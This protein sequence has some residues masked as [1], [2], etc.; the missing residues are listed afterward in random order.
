MTIAAAAR[1][2][3]EHLERD[4][5]LVLANMHELPFPARTFDFIGA[6]GIWDL[7]RSG[8]GSGARLAKRRV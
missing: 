5:R 1:V 4:L 8:R 3:D 6:H 7:A 2:R